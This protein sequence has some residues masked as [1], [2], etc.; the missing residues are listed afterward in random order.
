MLKF[1]DGVN[2]DTSGPLRMLRLKDGLY[3]VGQGSLI[4]M[5]DEDDVQAYL[6]AHTVPTGNIF[7][8]D[9]NEFEWRCGLDEMTKLIADRLAGTQFRY[10]TESEHEKWFEQ[11][12]EDISVASHEER[13]L[14]LYDTVD[15]LVLIDITEAMFIVPVS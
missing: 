3:V 4:P 1:T 9:P 12:A 10:A 13:G 7:T 11:L 15:G 6:Q 2:V 14:E 8:F 5:N